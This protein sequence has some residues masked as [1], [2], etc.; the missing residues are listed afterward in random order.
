MG[1]A[2]ALRGLGVVAL[3]EGRDAT[4]TLRASEALAAAVQDRHGALLSQTF[5][6]VAAPAPGAASEL[7]ALASSLSS[8]GLPREASLVR[9]LSRL[10]AGDTTAAASLLR[11]RPET[12][13][14]ADA[15]APSAPEAAIRLLLPFIPTA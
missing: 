13:T 8:L 10:R 7:E 4:E 6:A 1:E 14:I 2:N 9:A 15:V 11:E 3:L 5:L 12:A